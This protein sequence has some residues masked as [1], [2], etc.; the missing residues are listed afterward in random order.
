MAR[1]LTTF[2]EA[3]KRTNLAGD[4]ENKKRKYTVL[5]PT[6]EAFER[7]AAF[8]GTTVEDL[9]SKPFMREVMANVSSFFGGIFGTSAVPGQGEKN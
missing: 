7:T 3:L 5:A 2:V 6:N 4:V 9:L 1:N 8:F